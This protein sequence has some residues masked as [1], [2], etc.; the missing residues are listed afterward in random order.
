MCPIPGFPTNRRRRQ[1]NSN[2][3]Q[4]EEIRWGFQAAAQQIAPCIQKVGNMH[5]KIEFEKI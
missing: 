5:C 3:E 2:F 4:T 1:Q